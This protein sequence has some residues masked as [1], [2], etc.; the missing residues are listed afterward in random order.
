MNISIT[1]QNKFADSMVLNSQLRFTE[2]M[3]DLQS[4]ERT[5]Y[6]PYV[7]QIQ[8][9]FSLQSLHVPVLTNNY[10]SFHKE[11]S[12]EC[13]VLLKKLYQLCCIVSIHLY[14]TSCTV[15]QSEALPVRKTH[16]KESSVC[17]CSFY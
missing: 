9:K 17:L 8:Y 11:T 4:N 10:Y 5:T 1:K 6:E 12:G 2:D 13:I 16:R 7:G 15:H 3:N 14:S